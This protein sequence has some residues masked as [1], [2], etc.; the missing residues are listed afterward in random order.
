[1][2]L[3]YMSVSSPARLRFK[4]HKGLLTHIA[5]LIAHRATVHGAPTYIY[6]V[7]SHIGVLGNEAADQ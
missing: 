3:A 4:K 5:A 7:R 2:H 1:M 6:K